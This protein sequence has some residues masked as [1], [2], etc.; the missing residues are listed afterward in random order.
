P[1]D[2]PAD[3]PAASPSTPAAPDKDKDKDKGKD[4]EK[5]KD[6]DKKKAPEVAKIG[7]PAPDFKVTDLEGKAFSLAEATKAGKIVVLTW[8]NPGCPV[9]QFHYSTKT[10]FV[11]LAKKYTDKGVVFVA[12]NSGAPSQQGSG[13]AV[14]TEKKKE[15]K[16]PFQVALDESGKVGHM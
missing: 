4:K 9:V 10:T 13:K 8:F 12:I 1:S 2:K 5:D 16:I 3:P 11:D 15:W 7:E 6:K 14:N